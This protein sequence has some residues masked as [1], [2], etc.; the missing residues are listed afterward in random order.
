[1]L[2]PIREPSISDTVGFIEVSLNSVLAGNEPTRH[3]RLLNLHGGVTDLT[4]N[5]FVHPH[6]GSMPEDFESIDIKD[7]VAFIQTGL[8]SLND[9]AVDAI[10]ETVQRVGMKGVSKLF[11]FKE[12]IWM[13]GEEI[14]CMFLAEDVADRDESVAGMIT[15]AMVTH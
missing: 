11:R 2:K 9:E 5:I 7:L 4:L 8:P 3:V 14:V 12:S 1:M 15:A 6:P 10:I 13:V